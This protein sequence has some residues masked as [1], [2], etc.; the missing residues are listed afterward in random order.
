MVPLPAW[1]DPL[2]KKRRNRRLKARVIAAVGAAVVP[3]IDEFAFRSQQALS[4][5]CYINK[6]VIF[7]AFAL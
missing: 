4:C 6:Y 1:A 5:L 3:A 2:A 7:H